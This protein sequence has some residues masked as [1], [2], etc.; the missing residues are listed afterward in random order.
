MHFGC[1]VVVMCCSVVM[2]LFRMV[3]CVPFRSVAFGV[4][5]LFCFVSFCLRS[6]C[7]IMVCCCALS[8]LDVLCLF[9]V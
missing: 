3:S 6:V 1:G 8:L 2:L 5:C 7:L 9:G 4:C